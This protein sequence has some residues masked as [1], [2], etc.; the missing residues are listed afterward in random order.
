M[1][2]YRDA[3]HK[4]NILYKIG[5]NCFYEQKQKQN[6][7]YIWH[8]LNMRCNYRCNMWCNCK[9]PAK[10]YPSTPSISGPSVDSVDVS[11]S[12]TAVNFTYTPANATLDISFSST[13]G[14]IAYADNLEYSGWQ[15]HFTIYGWS[16]Y[17]NATVTY[18]NNDNPSET[19]NISATRTQPEPF[20]PTNSIYITKDTPW[21]AVQTKA[22]KSR[23]KTL[24]TAVGE[25][26]QAKMFA[27][28][29]SSTNY[30]LMKWIYWWD[31]YIDGYYWSANNEYTTNLFNDQAVLNKI[32]REIEDYDNKQVLWDNIAK[33]SG[34]T[35]Y[36]M[37]SYFNNVY[38]PEVAQ[39]IQWYIV[40]YGWTRFVTPYFNPEISDTSW[41]VWE[42][43]TIRW[44][45]PDGGWLI[46]RDQAKMVYVE[47]GNV[48][49]ENYNY[50]M[51]YQLLSEWTSAV[52]FQMY[53]WFTWTIDVTAYP[54]S[55]PVE[56]ISSTTSHIAIF[57]DDPYWSFDFNYSPTTASYPRNEIEVAYSWDISDAYMEDYVTWRGRIIVYPTDV[58]QWS[59]IVT[60]THTN[61]WETFDVSVT[62]WGAHVES[63]SEPS[64]S[65]VTLNVWQTSNNISIG[66]VPTEVGDASRDVRLYTDNGNVAQ[67]R[68]VDTTHWYICI[69]WI[70]PW[71]TQVHYWLNSNPENMYTIDVTVEE[72]TPTPGYV[73]NEHT[74]VYAPLKDTLNWE[75]GDW[76]I[77]TPDTLRLGATLEDETARFDANGALRYN[78]NTTISVA[79]MTVSLWVKPSFINDWLVAW[80]HEDWTNAWVSNDNQWFTTD[81]HWLSDYF[82]GLANN[83]WNLLTMVYDNQNNTQEAYINGQSVGARSYTYNVSQIDKIYL[84]AR[85]YDDDNIQWP[86]NGYVSDFIVEDVAWDAQMVSEYYE[87][88]KDN[89]PYVVVESVYDYPVSIALPETETYGFSLHYL[90]NNAPRITE[91]IHVVSSD[92]SIARVTYTQKDGDGQLDFWVEGVSAG[93][94]ELHVLLNDSLEATIPVTVTPFVHVESISQWETTAAVMEWES[95]TYAIPIMPSTV[96]DCGQDITVVSDDS[97][98]ANYYGWENATLWTFYLHWVSTGTTQLH[99]YLNSDTETVYDIDVTVN[100]LPYTPWENT[101]FYYPFISNEI[102]VTGLSYLSSGW[103][104]ADIWHTFNIVNQNDCVVVNSQDGTPAQANFIS[105]WIKWNESLNTTVQSFATY[106]GEVLFN[107]SHTQSAYNKVFQAHAN[108]QW[109]HSNTQDVIQWIWYHFAMWYDASNNKAVAYINWQKVWEQLNIYNPATSRT[110]L[111]MAINETLSDLIWES[112]CWTDEQ[113]SDYYEATKDSYPMPTH[114]VQFATND[115]EKWLVDYGEIECEVNTP[116][117]VNGNEITIGEYTITATAEQW[118]FFFSW[119]NAPQTISGDVTITANFFA[120]WE[121][122]ELSWSFDSVTSDTYFPISIPGYKVSQI[123]FSWTTGDMADWSWQWFAIGNRDDF[124]FWTA[125]QTGQNESYYNTSYYGE[126]RENWWTTRAFS[127]ANLWYWYTPTSFTSVMTKDDIT[128]N[129]WEDTTTYYFNDYSASQFIKGLL[130]RTDLF[131]TISPSNSVCNSAQITVQYEP[132]VLVSELQNVPQAITQT[133]N[134]NTSY[135]FNYLPIN[136]DIVDIEITSDNGNVQIASQRDDGNGVYVFELYWAAEGQDSLNIYLNGNLNTTIPVEVQSIHVDTFSGFAESSI[137]LGT[138]WVKFVPLTIVPNNVSDIVQDITITSDDD[139][140]AAIDI[141]DNNNWIITIIGASEWQTQVHAYLNSDPSTVYDLD[142]SVAEATANYALETDS[143]E[144]NGFYDDLIRNNATFTTMWNANCVELNGSSSYLYTDNALWQASISGDADFTLNIWV[145]PRSLPTGSDYRAIAEFWAEWSN[146]NACIFYHTWTL[147]IGWW[148]NDRDTGTSLPLYEWSMVTLTHSGGTAKMYVDGS[149]VHT[150]TVNFNISNGGL[151]VLWAWLWRNDQFLNWYINGF[152]ISAREFTAGEISNMYINWQPDHITKPISSISNIASE[153]TATVWQHSTVKLCDYLPADADIDSLLIDYNNY[154]NIYN[155]ILDNGEY[156]IEIDWR[157]TW[158]STLNFSLNNVGYSAPLKVFGLETVTIEATSW[159][160]IDTQSIAVPNGTPIT[161]S[162]NTITIWADTITA[163]PDTDYSVVWDAPSEVPAWWCNIVAAFVTNKTVDDIHLGITPWGNDSSIY[164][165]N[166]TPFS[167]PFSYTPTDAAEAYN[168]ITYNL[169]PNGAPTWT[170]TI[171]GVSYN[172]RGTLYITVLLENAVDYDDSWILEFK[173]SSSSD[174]ESIYITALAADSTFRISKP[175]TNNLNVPAWQTLQGATYKVRY[176]PTTVTSLV[177]KRKL[178]FESSDPT[179]AIWYSNTQVSAS[180]GTIQFKVQ[181]ITPGECTL[182]YYLVDSPDVKYTMGV[183]VTPA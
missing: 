87:A 69:D 50:Y 36:R 111:G 121:T 142:V 59:G 145:C 108:N 122:P 23:K 132:A 15:W 28:D 140:I 146:Y 42:T 16:G 114:T 119:T 138:W 82:W 79:P 168:D 177:A 4:P 2:I 181:W 157:Q 152:T 123:E 163:T 52:W 26:Y 14:N 86:W 161:V 8:I 179:I 30:V 107:F 58:Q 165:S 118:N 115:P 158:T 74:M 70:N 159:W 143:S 135:N 164:L 139:S 83:G 88:T 171:T 12:S 117:V 11:T 153:I 65:S 126:I 166:D 37:E 109:P 75:D 47:G 71:Y 97:S 5:V 99:Y 156:K 134:M 173:P 104:R 84:W 162:W 94:A 13:D 68:W 155:Y 1:N 62:I 102:D 63:V 160:S 35:W 20:S 29:S 60:V 130:A 72:P 48:W 27:V 95:S 39:A 7:F 66:Q 127:Q 33:F 167:I 169:S 144:N 131:A 22:K 76:N 64:E 149:L 49:E 34:G 54:G 180:N 55:T 183:T 110:P 106:M 136:A 38:S 172:G 43:V 53:D 147:W 6:F 81:V 182:T 124:W 90:P 51:T 129:Y 176:T 175:Y 89:Y 120:E 44:W 137:A 24:A 61:S 57:E 105:A 45:K 93:S 46:I 31:A 98:I 174:Y 112:Q 80:Y 9:K 85:W 170:A 25:E 128:Y 154:I 73:V 17:G 148:E 77:I 19:Y 92:D 116:V 96:T 21:E 56:H 125:V 78:L 67:I 150:D 151:C 18:I 133:Y 41:N 100:P 141:M 103:D 91:Q 178:I 113:V 10:P 101:V 32:A 3:K 40:E